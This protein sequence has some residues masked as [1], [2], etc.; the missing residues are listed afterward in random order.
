MAAITVTAAKRR[1]RQRR[2][3]RAAS[4]RV[5][6]PSLPRLPVDKKGRTIRLAR[7]EEGKLRY[8]SA[9]AGTTVALVVSKLM[10][11]NGHENSA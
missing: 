7:R 11:R 6:A 5:D 4:G 2:G 3:D 1:I 10:S 8:V 9:S